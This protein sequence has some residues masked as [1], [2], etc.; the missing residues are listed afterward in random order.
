MNVKL[1]TVTEPDYVLGTFAGIN[2]FI[3]HHQGGE[4]S[5]EINVI[6]N[7][8][9]P[10]P[11]FQSIPFFKINVLGR[12]HFQEGSRAPGAWQ[13]KTYALADLSQ[14]EDY[15][16]IIGFDADLIFTSNVM[17]IARLSHEHGLIF[18]GEDGKRRPVDQAFSVYP[19]LEQ[20]DQMPCY[21]STS[22]Y[23]WPNNETTRRI[24]RIAGEYTDSACYGPAD[25][26]AVYPGHGDQGILNYTV[27]SETKH[28]DVRTLPNNLWSQHWTGWKDSLTIY[29]GEVYN[30]SEGNTQR[31]LHS[32]GGMPKFWGPRFRQML[33]KHQA[34]QLTAYAAFLGHLWFGE[35]RPVLTNERL[36]TLGVDAIRYFPLIREL[37]PEAEMRLDFVGHTLRSKKVRSIMPPKT[38]QVYDQLV[39]EAKGTIVEVGSYEGGSLT[40]M[41]A[42]NADRR[43]INFVSVESFSGDLN[44]KV[45]NM[46]LPSLQAFDRALSSFG[47]LPVSC[48]P[49]SSRNAVKH[50]EDGSI[51]MV[52]IDAGHGT[53]DVIE[54]IKLWAPKVRKGG[55]IAGDDWSWATVMK[56][57]TQSLGTDINESG[58]LWWVI[59]E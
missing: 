53:D 38:L 27:F 47:F 46:V 29:G 32:T 50:F 45:D 2:S 15:H 22:C 41:A 23:F 42:M 3:H 52:M 26:P 58:N 54:D 55:I 36:E 40:T 30:A 11:D 39:K 14:D 10:R 7:S 9:E 37:I 44:G 5:F 43:D 18:G 28:V 16:V 33:K 12:D 8:E 24:A 57:V 17:D 19:N 59:K 25:R 6:W 1:I 34:G 48:L 56:G 31:T 13:L 49:L 4:D 20:G 35:F 21:F 51:G